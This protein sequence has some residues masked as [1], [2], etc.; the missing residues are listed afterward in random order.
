[1]LGRRERGREG[2]RE[3]GRVVPYLFQSLV[4]F[5][6]ASEGVCLGQDD[7]VGDG[8]LVKQ[9]HGQ[10]GGR[11]G[12]RGGGREGGVSKDEGHV[13]RHREKEW[14]EIAKGNEKKKEGGR[15]GGGR[16][17]WCVPHPAS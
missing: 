9:V 15:E 12:G 13:E 1:M 5:G 3:G 6:L 2:G 10:L 16:V 17:R 8:V 7:L 4:Q 11:E 14:G